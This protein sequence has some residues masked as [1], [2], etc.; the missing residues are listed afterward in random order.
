M[1]QRTPEFTLLLLL[2]PHL[3]QRRSLWFAAVHQSDS[4]AE[5]RW[6]A[7]EAHQSD[8]PP[9]E[10]IHGLQVRCNKS[11]PSLDSLPVRKKQNYNMSFFC[12]FGINR[13]GLTDSENT[14][15]V[16]G[17]KIFQVKAGCEHKWYQ[18][19]LG[20]CTDLSSDW[21]LNQTDPSVKKNKWYCLYLIYVSQS[22][23][24][25][26]RMTSCSLWVGLRCLFLVDGGDTEGRTHCIDLSIA[27]IK[28]S[29]NKRFRWC[30]LH[31]GHRDK[32][33]MK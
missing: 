25:D 20:E 33:W 26:V 4:S 18:A 7:G 17:R 13:K 14:K 12:L 21:A 10:Q 2:L 8:H 6:A 5:V 1:L 16:W 29:E 9:S 23:W 11:Y 19:A 22:M 30:F 24:S 27:S 3:H 28:I 32:W 31:S 15:Q